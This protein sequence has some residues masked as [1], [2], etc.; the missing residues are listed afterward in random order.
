MR[1][2]AA[3]RVY[4][5]ALT[6]ALTL[7]GAYAL[8][9]PLPFLA[10]LFALIL[11]AKPGPPL[12]LK[13]LLGLILVVI[14]TLSA[15]LLMIPLLLN[16]PVSAILIAAVGLF[17]SN[18]LT[19]NLGKGLVG[20]L[21][22]VGI[23]MISAAGLVSYV[24][25]TTVIQALVISIA[26]AMLCQWLVYP[27]F[28]EDQT[29]AQKARTKDRGAAASNWIALRAT[30]IVLPAY[31][32]ALTDPTTYMPVIMKS[33]QLGQQDSV[34]NAR[35]AGT[36]LLGSTFLAGC[37]AVLFWLALKLFPSLWM[38]FLL[39]L[40][41]SLYLSAKFYRVLATRLSPSFWQNTAVTLLILLGPAVEDSANGKDVYNA[42]AMRMTLFIAVTLYA[43]LALHVLERLRLRR[44]RR[45][46]DSLTEELPAC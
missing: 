44:Q 42:F 4:R 39:M 15:G 6:V 37:L 5:L 12:G 43:W 35:H 46:S 18:Y 36:E 22:T 11:T 45:R 2:L 8:A 32:L 1:P 10:P 14:I 28:P 31:L 9:L 23:A 16:Y 19:V 27:W 33:V 40:A 24:L 34:T 17:F 26:L 13:A 20:A 3:R 29:A 41:F 7:A 21:L 30:I 25:A 38:Y